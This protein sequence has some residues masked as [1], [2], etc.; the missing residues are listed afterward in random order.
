VFVC[1]ITCIDFTVYSQHYFY[2]FV[3][4]SLIFFIVD[5]DTIRYKHIF[6]FITPSLFLLEFIVHLIV[7]LLQW[8]S[9][10]IITCACVLDFENY[11]DAT[12]NRSLKYLYTYN[13]LYSEYLG[14]LISVIANRDVKQIFLENSQ[15]NIL[16]MVRRIHTK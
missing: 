16:R 8:T 10:H 4:F 11:T 2:F 3:F 15:Y 5:D 13:G 7:F 12:A 1:N 9:Q 6:E 14:R